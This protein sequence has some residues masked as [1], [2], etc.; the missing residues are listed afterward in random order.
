MDKRRVWIGNMIYMFDLDGTLF[1]TEISTYDKPIPDEA[2][3]TLVNM[4]YDQGH[5]IKIFTA[6]GSSSGI[7]YRDRTEKQLKEFGVKYHELIFGKPSADVIIDD[8]SMTPEEFL[9]EV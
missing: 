6:R 9:N 1:D 4:L 3:I 5:T 8:I 2:M 7:D